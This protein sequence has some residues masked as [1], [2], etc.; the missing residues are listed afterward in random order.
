M[1]KISTGKLSIAFVASLMFGVT[2]L[3]AASYI[4]RANTSSNQDDNQKVVTQACRRV[5]TSGNPLNVRSSP[6]GT[7]IGTLANGTIVTIEGNASNGWVMISSPQK[8]MVFEQ[9]LTSCDANTTTTTTQTTATQTKPE[10]TAQGMC[11]RVKTAGAPLNVRSSPNGAIIGTV[12]NGTEVTVEK[13]VN[14]AWV[15]IS[16]PQKGMVFT[17]Y[18]VPCS[19]KTA[20][21][22]TATATSTE[23]CRRILSSEAVSVKKEPS[24][25]SESV[26]T[27]VNQQRVT[28]VNRGANGWVPISEP[29]NG[30]IPANKLIL[31]PR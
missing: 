12:A 26:G 22:T 11:R 3:T 20:T 19:E 14:N 16:S 2:N 13:N 15:M 23:N 9:Y 29:V 21:G 24:A 7:I 6:N 25:T 17:A 4:A 27:L 8:G 5:K 28:I 10:T 31:C 18:L 30:Y 1:K